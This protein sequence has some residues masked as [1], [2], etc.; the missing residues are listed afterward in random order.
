MAL[1]HEVGVVIRRLLRTIFLAE[2][3]VN[4][5]FRRELLRVLNRGEATNALKRL[6]YPGRVAYCQ[7]KSEDEMQAVTDALSLPAS[8]EGNHAHLLPFRAQS[9]GI[10]E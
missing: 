8:I 7:A 10:S 4:P 3:F 6:I 2:Y 9:H 5:A 1:L